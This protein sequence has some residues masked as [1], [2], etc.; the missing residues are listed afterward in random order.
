MY[1]IENDP[2]LHMRQRLAT[3]LEI[4]V[5]F[6]NRRSNRR[7]RNLIKASKKPYPK[8]ESSVMQRPGIASRSAKDGDESMERDEA[9]D[10]CDAAVLGPVGSVALADQE[11]TIMGPTLT[12]SNDLNVDKAFDWLSTGAAPTV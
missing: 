6:Q 2:P 12:N 8:M 3:D 1:E 5:W 9:S 7:D 4:Q 10:H 11:G